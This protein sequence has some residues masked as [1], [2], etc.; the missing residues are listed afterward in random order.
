MLEILTRITKG[1]GTEADI[2]LLEEMG[3]IVKDASLC[4]L[5][6]TCPNPVLS[7][8]RISAMSTKPILEDKHCPAGSCEALT[9]APC[10]NT[11]PLRVDAVGYVALIGAGR[12]EE[13]LRVHPPQYAVG[14]GLGRVCN[15]PC[16]SMC[17]RGEIDEPIAICTLKRFAADWELKKG[18][19][20]RPLS[21]RRSR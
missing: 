2:A 16:E 10:E 9:Y 19:W 15:H 13:A 21:S 14:R 3:P 4:G 20:P 6:Q 17:K 8:I 12:F 11:C 7:T 18:A 1:E 5:G